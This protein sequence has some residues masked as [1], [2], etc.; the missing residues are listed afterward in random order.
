MGYSCETFGSKTAADPQSP[1]Y[2]GY[3]D[4][5]RTTLDA[6]KPFIV[7]TY[8][9]SGHFLTVIGIDDM[10]TAYPYHDVIITA[11][12]CDY[13]DGHQDGYNVYSAYKFYRQH[14]NSNHT[15]QFISMVIDKPQA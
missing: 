12:S 8:L 15:S 2:E 13:W 3:W 6:G 1:T 9:G 11:D 7:S 10:G 14:T 4:F 5:I